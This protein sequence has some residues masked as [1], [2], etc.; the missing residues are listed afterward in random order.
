MRL[1][2]RY[3]VLLIL[4]LGLFILWLVHYAA[5]SVIYG[6]QLR[7]LKAQVRAEGSSLSLQELAARCA[8][9]TLDPSVKNEDLRPVPEY[10]NAAFVYQAAGPLLEMRC[11][12]NTPGIAPYDAFLMTKPSERAK[13]V[14]KNRAGLE[15][16]LRDSAMPLQLLHQAAHCERSW[17]ELPY[18]EGYRMQLSSFMIH[19]MLGTR[20]LSLEAW[21][22]AE[23]GDPHKALQAVWAALRIRHALENEPLEM[24]QVGGMDWDSKTL[25]ALQCILPA[26]Q[27]QEADLRL[28]LTELQSRNPASYRLAAES[29][30]AT[31]EDLFEVARKEGF[32]G[33]FQAVEG[34]TATGWQRFMR[35]LVAAKVR[36]L[37]TLPPDE[38]YYLSVMNR[39][40]EDAAR[41]P[42]LTRA[43]LQSFE[44]NAE[45]S[46]TVPDSPFYYADPRSSRPL[47]WLLLQSVNPLLNMAKEDVARRD[48]A[49]CGIAAELYRLDHGAYPKSLEALA[50]KYLATLPNDTFSG[51][52][53]LLKS[54]PDGVLIYSVGPNGKDDGGVND[55]SR[56][57]GTPPKSPADDIAWRVERTAAA[58]KAP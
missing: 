45:T 47:S 28:I 39:F 51:Q 2:R 36:A 46:P 57:G 26:L 27:P 8:G 7:H 25:R 23:Q 21:L 4:V 50:P 58:A 11:D 40:V 30:R 22:A 55:Q 42:S 44:K 16:W 48:V 41:V 6:I 13:Q 19:L 34:G 18:Y 43:E 33:V 37:N 20:L 24:S 1:P 35:I 53:L 9:V 10:E 3:R 54:L 29:E 15:A 56:A 49:E 32:G 5:V 38:A 14:S 12:P 31:G 52:P 17:F